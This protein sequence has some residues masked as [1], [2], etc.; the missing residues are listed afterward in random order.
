MKGAEDLRPVCV[1]KE[2]AVVKARK[3]VQK[4][5]ICGPPIL[6]EELAKTLK[7]NFDY[8]MGAIN[9]PFAFQTGGQYY[10]ALNV[11]SNQGR[12]NWSGIHEIAHIDLDH[13]RVYDIGTLDKPVL[14]CKER[15]ILDKEADIYAREVLMPRKWVLEAVEMPLTACQVGDLKDLFMVSWRAMIL[16]LEELE[17]AKRNEIT[18]LFKEARSSA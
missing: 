13:F 15:Q 9:Y 17:I 2:Y 5:G 6:A 18:K 16:R 14:T 10:I 11:T 4:M 8:H 7:I 12:N 1:R 3:A